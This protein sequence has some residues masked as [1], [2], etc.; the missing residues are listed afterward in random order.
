MLSL[1]PLSFPPQLEP[2]RGQLDVGELAAG[3]AAGLR[4]T[5]AWA[6][7][8]ARRAYRAAMLAW[9]ALAAWVRVRTAG[10]GDRHAWT[11]Y[12]VY[13]F[14]E[15]PGNDANKDPKDAAG[16]DANDAAKGLAFHE[17]PPRFFDPVEWESNARDATGWE[18]VK[19]EV[20]YRHRGVKYRMVLRPGDECVFP[21]E[22][23]PG[24]RMLPCVLS[25][26]LRMRT[27]GDDYMD[28]DVT[29]RVLKYQGATRDFH[30]STVTVRDLFPF[31]DH[32]T[33]MERF[34]H[35]RVV[36]SLMRVRVIS[37][38]SDASVAPPPL[39]PA[40]CVG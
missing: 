36:D 17:I 10:S 19:V 35:L 14:D 33:N 13:V 24:M 1:S 22:P 27:S 7:S 26:S 3:L 31:D 5:W 29:R 12:R 8:R 15:D 20:R 32:D 34:V 23:A 9:C 37:Y 4:E 40:S 18:H 39:V 38:S 28:V 2:F 11:V 6:C 21:P 25:A 30:G 16:T